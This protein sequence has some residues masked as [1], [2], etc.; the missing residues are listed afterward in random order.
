MRINQSQEDQI[1][2]KDIKW[3][4]LAKFKPVR[5]KFSVTSVTT[6]HWNIKNSLKEIK[7]KS[8]M[9]WKAG[10]ELYKKL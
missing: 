7:T 4:I 1:A 6:T 9:K 5:I 3:L 2:V 8:W 10:Q